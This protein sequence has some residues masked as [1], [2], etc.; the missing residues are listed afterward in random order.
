MTYLFII[1]GISILN[2]LVNKKISYAEL[3]FTNLAIIGTVWGFERIWLLK[4]ESTKFILYEKIEMVKPENYNLLL[5]DLNM[6][7]GLEINRAEVGK[8]NFMR[9]TAE[10]KI[11]YFNCMNN[12]GDFTSFSDEDYQ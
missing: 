9:D 10:I 4:H 3:V 1:I 12:A 7:T 5:L 11:Y 8:I 2:A 6:R